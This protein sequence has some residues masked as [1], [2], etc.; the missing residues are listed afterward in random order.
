MGSRAEGLGAPRPPQPPPEPL[1]RG[2]RSASAGQLRAPPAASQS[3]Q[4]PLVDAACYLCCSALPQAAPLQNVPA[5]LY[6][7]FGF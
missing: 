7:A 1:P 2:S 3:R 5:L 4:Q 6:I